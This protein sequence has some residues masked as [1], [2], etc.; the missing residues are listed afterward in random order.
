[1]QP[2]KAINI[3]GTMYSI[4]KKK[5]NDDPSFEKDGS[6]GYCSQALHQI[7]I[8][9]MSTYPGWDETGPENI[10]AI[11]KQTLRHEIVHAFFNESG[12]CFNANTVTGAWSVNEEMVD[13]I[14]LQGPK[15]Y[16]AWQ[17]VG[18]V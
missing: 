13:W 4:S 8:C 16:A 11:E 9:D 10:D 7:V 2:P 18:A 15:I 3:L 1:M 5:Y 14:A 6:D 17:A 12:L